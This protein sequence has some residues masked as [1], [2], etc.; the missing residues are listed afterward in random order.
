MKT[1]DCVE[2]KRR[3]AS[4]VQKTLEAFSEEEEVRFWLQETEALRQR[5][6]RLGRTPAPAQLRGG[7]ARTPP[8]A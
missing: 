4:E 2:M 1:F 8:P 3:G 5:Q 6:E 7:A